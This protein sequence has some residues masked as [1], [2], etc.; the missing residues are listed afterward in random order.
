MKK[1]LLIF[2][3]IP[4]FALCQELPYKDGDIVY[5]LTVQNND[6]SKKEIFSRTTD[7]VKQTLK[8]GSV[9]V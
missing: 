6:L 9:F 7:F 8:K 2:L 1:L 4:V 3:F 5:E